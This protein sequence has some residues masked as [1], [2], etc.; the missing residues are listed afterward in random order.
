MN[1]IS[2]RYCNDT[3]PKVVLRK[4]DWDGKLIEISLCEQ[5]KEDPDFS[6]FIS[7]KELERL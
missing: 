1:D 6:H 2:P 7:E 4:F 3:N 5:H